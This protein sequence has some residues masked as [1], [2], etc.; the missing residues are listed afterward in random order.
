[1]VEQFFQHNAQRQNTYGKL[2]SVDNVDLIMDRAAAFWDA[3]ADEEPY[4]HT[5]QHPYEEGNVVDRT[6]VEDVAESEPV[7]KYLN[8]G[9]CIVPE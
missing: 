9:V 8:R 3:R 4:D 6:S 5:S 7:G 1:M 2:H